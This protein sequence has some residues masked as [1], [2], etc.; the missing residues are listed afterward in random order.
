[1]GGG[2]IR[3]E[4]R[5]FGPEFP[6]GNKLDLTYLHPDSELF[7][8]VRVA[9]L[10]NA[11]L[12]KGAGNDPA[13]NAVPT[14]LK[15]QIGMELQIL[16]TVTFVANAELNKPPQPN[17]FAMGDQLKVFESLHAIAVI[18]SSKPIEQKG[19]RL[20]GEAKREEAT[21]AGT[22]Y[23]RAPHPS[24]PPV[25]LAVY[26]PDA[27]T[28]V[29]GNELD[30]KQAIEH[31]GQKSSRTATWISSIRRITFCSRCWPRIPRG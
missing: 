13:A 27:T 2:R 31:R 12:V 21:H 3:G 14:P 1:M 10:L 8:H 4:Q 26:F 24:T 16:Q 11:P 29:T 25:D 9:D 23:Y 7:V 5:A 19:F 17:N 20:V 15:Q 22:T 28:A 6:K 18:R 30:I